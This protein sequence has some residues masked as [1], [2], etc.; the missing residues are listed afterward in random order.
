MSIRLN[1]RWS[2]KLRDR[3]K[4]VGENSAVATMVA[5]ISL[6]AELSSAS[7]FVIPTTI[8][9]IGSTILEP[10]LGVGVALFAFQVA[11]VWS[12]RLRETDRKKSK[13]AELVKSDLIEA[14]LNSLRGLG[15]GSAPAREGMHHD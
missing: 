11:V 8:A 9:R 12:R 1:I 3:L 2:E 14:T 13:E 7:D 15:L 4:L 10:V 5:V 6:L